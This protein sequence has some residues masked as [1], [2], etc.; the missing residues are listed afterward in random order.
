MSR[1]MVTALLAASLA[2][3]NSTTV[4]PPNVNVSIGQQLIDLKKAR[5]AGALSEK[6]Y[7]RQRE[8]LI[9]SVR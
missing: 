4:M 9:D 1:F 3:C 7:Q 6:E 2:A 5:D 8:D